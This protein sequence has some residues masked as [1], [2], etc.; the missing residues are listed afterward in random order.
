MTRPQTSLAVLG[1][2]VLSPSAFFV[3]F[4]WPRAFPVP[5]DG[6]RGAPGSA[7]VGALGRFFSGYFLRWLRWRWFGAQLESMAV[8]GVLT[9]IGL[10][11]IGMPLAPLL[12]LIAG[13]LGFVPNI[14]P[15]PSAIPAVLLAST[16][17]GTAALLTVGVVL[18]VQA[19]ES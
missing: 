3:I 12:G 8:V 1:A 10:W 11:L 6:S 18:L 19:L 7:G 15:I 4:C 5:A 16:E 13:L 9:P 14:G 2:G 17:G